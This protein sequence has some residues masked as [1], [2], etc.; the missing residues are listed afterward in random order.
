VWARKRR[1]QRANVETVFGRSL[2]SSMWIFIL[3]NGVSF[4][5]TF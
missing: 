3:D 2:R 4:L 5:Q 1:A